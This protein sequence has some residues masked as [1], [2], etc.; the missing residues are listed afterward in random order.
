MKNL[1]LLLLAALSLTQLIPSQWV[2]QQ[3]PNNASYFI[4]LDFISL[5][6]GAAGG[7]YSNNFTGRG[8]YTTNSGTNWFVSTVPDSCRV[9]LDIEFVGNSTGFCAGAYN[10]SVLNNSQSN[11]G[12]IYDKKTY[13]VINNPESFNG[14]GYKGLFLKTVNGGQSWATFGSL[15]VNVYYMLGMDFINETTGY[16]IVSYDFSGGVND[17]VIKTTNGG[18]NWFTLPMPEIINHLSDIEFINSSTGFA[19]GYDKVNDSARGVILKTTNSGS[20]W[21]RQVS[22]QHMQY[23]NICFTDQNTGIVISGLTGLINYPASNIYKT[24]NSGLSWSLITTLQDIELQDVNFLK[25]TGTAFVCGS[26]YLPGFESIDYSSK[27]SNYGSSWQAG[28]FNDTG[29]GFFTS[30]LLNN[31]SWYLAGGNFDAQLSPVILHTSNGTPIG[32]INEGN[33]LPDVFLLEQNYPNPFNP[34][35]NIKF[36][37][38]KSSFVLLSVY[39]IN[40]SE[41]SQLV[42]QQM[43]PGS[44]NASWNAA[45]LSSG[46]YFYVLESG[47]FKETKKMILL[48]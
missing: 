28:T 47:S 32:I 38:P 15:P 16:A 42:A 35:T 40:G 22:S 37:I 7:I 48:K 34:S 24:T 31:S 27:S 14:A 10:T 19:V 1:F 9:M 29:L 3:V 12:L 23:R 11:T 36:S 2:Y 33:Q 26:R 18:V 5:T 46:I 45:G 41:V 30:E 6:N 44:Y 20:S 13:Q 8:V 43:S 4:S 17:G 25:G 21:Q 39:D